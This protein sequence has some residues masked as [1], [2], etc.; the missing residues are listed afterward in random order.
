MTRTPLH[1]GLA[2]CCCLLSLSPTAR[3]YSGSG[4]PAEARGTAGGYYAGRGRP[5]SAAASRILTGST[6][7]DRLSAV[8]RPPS[9][10]ASVL[11]R[12]RDRI[13]T[14]SGRVPIL[15]PVI[16]LAG[17]TSPPSS[18]E[19][20]DGDC[21][22]TDAPADTARPAGGMDEVDVA[23]R[24]LLRSRGS[25][26]V[27]AEDLAAFRG[28]LDAVVAEDVAKTDAPDDV[29]EEDVPEDTLEFGIDEQTRMQLEKLRPAKESKKL[30]LRQQEF[31]PEGA[32]AEETVALEGTGTKNSNPFLS[33]RT[34]IKKVKFDEEAYMTAWKEH[35]LSEVLTSPHMEL[36]AEELNLLLAPKKEARHLVV[37]RPDSGYAAIFRM[38]GTVVDL[39]GVQLEAWSKVAKENGF[40]PP[41]LQQVTYAQ[42]MPAE[43][44]VQ[45]AMSWSTDFLEC[46]R[47]A[48]EHYRA[49]G[50]I[51]NIWA[52]WC[53]SP[54]S[55]PAL[56]P[57]EALQRGR[58]L[59]PP[60]PGALEFVSGLRDSGV[61]C[62]LVSRLD[63][64]QVTRILDI[65]G[66]SK[67][68]PPAHLVCADDRRDRESQE[69][70]G[71]ALAMRTR[72]DRCVTFGTS[73]H[74]AVEAHEA[75]MRAV[76]FVGTYPQY[77]LAVSDLTARGYADMDAMSVRRIFSDSLLDVT[78]ETEP[79]RLKETEVKK[80]KRDYWGNWS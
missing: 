45:R 14:R 12:L 57:E 73:P 40:R 2:A 13:G 22:A 77:D 28:R 36:R 10:G 52:D 51:F 42:T 44:A 17:S 65:T 3:A 67:L 76:S 18:T 25:T 20:N 79:E 29:A 41:T 59:F 7:T 53:A 5:R 60:V 11:G 75:T 80:R 56:V 74:A 55:E 64:R 58:S 72:P 71:A 70:M 8:S 35:R 38:E 16:P 49:L 62:S 54:D 15:V 1:Q 26:G 48:V 27:S 50:E 6:Y 23:I 24:E 34:Q 63:R 68:F 47:L 46:R 9:A 21:A 33:D 61:S 78:E 43:R 4:A 30:R 39:S 19:R 32:A 69:F 66:T 37:N 31:E